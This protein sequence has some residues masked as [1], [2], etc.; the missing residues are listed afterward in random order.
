VS[1][2][3]SSLSEAEREIWKD[4]YRF[5]ATFNRMGN[6][7]EEWRQCATAVSQLSEKHGNHPLV[8]SLLVAVYGYLSDMRKPLAVAEAEGAGGGG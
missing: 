8:I 5:C 4:A 6:T 1:E 3:T 2:K 7:D